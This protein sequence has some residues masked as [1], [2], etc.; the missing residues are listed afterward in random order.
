ML[1]GA[2]DQQNRVLLFTVLGI[3]VSEDLE[4][5]DRIGIEFRARHGQLSC[6]VDFTEV[7][8]FAVPES[9]LAQR[10]QQPQIIP[11]LVMVASRLSGG[12]GGRVFKRY[13]R[14]AGQKEAALAANLEEA[15]ALLGLRNPRFEPIE[16]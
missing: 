4:E 12:E 15:Y 1:S 16:R 14:E 9:R 11:E 10:A 13:Q 5:L 2:F 6:I 8:A 7:E 3:F